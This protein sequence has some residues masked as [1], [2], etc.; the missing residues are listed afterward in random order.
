MITTLNKHFIRISVY[1]LVCAVL[2]TASQL[3][4]AYTPADKH[5]G[6]SEWGKVWSLRPN[7]ILCFRFS[8]YSN[9]KKSWEKLYL[10]S[11]KPSFQLHWAENRLRHVGFPHQESILLAENCSQHRLTNTGKHS[12]PWRLSTSVEA[13]VVGFM[14]SVCFESNTWQQLCSDFGPC[15]HLR[16]LWYRK[17]EL[18]GERVNMTGWKKVKVNIFGCGYISY[19][20]LYF[21]LFHLLA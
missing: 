15:N 11:D 12:L 3:G 19:I 9:T 20:Y 4:T 5:S 2:E 18:Q 1:L 21:L 10:I 6:V 16:T 14:F 13:T 8:V 7:T 17:H